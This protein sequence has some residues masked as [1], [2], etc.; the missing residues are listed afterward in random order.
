MPV[1]PVV[2]RVEGRADRRAEDQ[3]MVFP[4]GPGG[5][6]LGVLARRCARSWT[7]SGAG[8]ARISFACPSRA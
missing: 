2:M 5:E 1:I 3:V 7:M 6:A 8:T 4:C